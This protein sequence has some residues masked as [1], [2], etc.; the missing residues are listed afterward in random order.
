MNTMKGIDL[1]EV[2]PFIDPNPA[3]E[4]DILKRAK[5]QLDSAK[6]FGAI[7]DLMASLARHFSAIQNELAQLVKSLSILNVE[8]P[9]TSLLE[10]FSQ[11]FN[12][13]GRQFVSQSNLSLQIIRTVVLPNIEK[14]NTDYQEQINHYGR[15]AENLGVLEKKNKAEDASSAE[16]AFIKAAISRSGHLY[17]LHNQ[18]TLAEKT[19]S[20]AVSLAIAQF[21]T[22]TANLMSQYITE[23]RNTILFTQNSV[24]EMQSAVKLLLLQR[25][26]SDPDNNPA[27]T[28]SS[29]YWDMRFS[30]NSPTVEDLT[31]PAGSVWVKEAHPIR[32][33]VW[34]RKYLTFEDSLLVAHKI[35]DDDQ[36]KQWLLPLVTVTPLDKTR[37][38]AF[39]IQSPQELIEIQALSK[40]DMEEWLTVFTNH[41]FK[42]LGQEENK[43]S[44]KCCD[45]GA[46]DATWISLNWACDLCLKC[47]GSH[48]HM[49]TTNSKIRSITLDKLSPMVVDMMTE[50]EGDCNRLLLAKT[51][52]DKINSR[53]EDTVRDQ[54]ITRKYVNFEWAS[55]EPVPDPFTTILNHNIHALFH[56]AHFGKIDEL[57]QGITPLHA[58][59][60]IGDKNAV[61]L[62]TY[63][64]QSMNVRDPRGWTPLC[65]AV[66]FQHVEIIQF[67]LANGADAK[68]V[69]INLYQLAIAT[70]NMKVARMILIVANPLRNDEN[71]FQ[72]ITLKYA[73]PGTPEN[74]KLILKPTTT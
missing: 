38:F 62:L 36:D 17:S 26:G 42:V 4:A 53:S 12:I 23:N 45:C 74:Y 2:F 27:T 51:P 24:F 35:S 22:L 66:F 19:S 60:S 10:N 18:V 69:G 32:S 47:S 13:W 67:L 16:T 70:K 25:I 15:S 44:K 72:P 46:S 43:A 1:D 58:A 73:P 65:Y 21:I 20:R 33:S 50:L 5:I 37:R 40:L 63:C 9:Y 41:N 49:S 11:M 34:T 68:D 52:K 71:V 56:A 30:A 28:A 55:S 48:R 6:T 54:Y 3:F 39:K 59:C 8:D 61:C 14:L 7:S 31:K 64:V 29:T 57:D